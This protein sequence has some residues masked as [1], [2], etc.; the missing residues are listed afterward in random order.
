MMN[1]EGENILKKEIIFSVDSASHKDLK[2]IKGSSLYVDE[3]ESPPRLQILPIP[4]SATPPRLQTQESNTK[5]SNTIKKVI[6]KEGEREY[7]EDK[8][9]E[10]KRIQLEKEKI[11][12]K[13][14]TTKKWSLEEKDFL[15]ENQLSILSNSFV[16]DSTSPSEVDKDNIKIYKSEIQ[17]KINSYRSQDILKNIYLLEKFV[18]FQY[19]IQLLFE[20]NLDCFYCKKKVLIVYENVREPRQWSLERI[21]NKFGHNKDNVMI[22][23]L[24]CNLRRRTMYHERFVFTKQMCNIKKIE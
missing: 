7:K 6:Y 1:K 21:D 19:V 4:S 24:S 5:D 23:C 13:I 9:E 20:S 16:F 8:K 22:A 15:F 14:T 17:N 11:L 18:D 12:R 2:I 3:V 10:G